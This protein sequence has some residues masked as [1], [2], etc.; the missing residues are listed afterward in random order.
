MNKILLAPFL[1]LFFLAG[2]NYA[3][4]AQNAKTDSLHNIISQQRKDVN[5]YLALAAL[6]DHFKGTK[7]DS[8]VFYAEKVAAA[9]AGKDF[10]VARITANGAVGYA[11][12]IKGELPLASA[13]FEDNARLN[14]L[15]NDSAGVANAVNNQGN[16]LLEMGN[17]SGALEKYRA[18]LAVMEAIHNKK[19]VA[20]ANNNIGYIYK[21]LGDYDRAIASMLA[22]LRTMEQLGD[23][24]SIANNCTMLSAVYTRKKDF[25]RAAEYARRAKELYLQTGQNQ[26]VGISLSLLANVYQE[27]GKYDEAMNTHREALAIYEKAG[28][29]RQI[30]NTNGY[31]GEILS[32]QER[33]AEAIPYIDSSI[34]ILQKVSRRSLGSAWLS[35]ARNYINTKNLKGSRIH[36]DSAAGIIAE[37]KNKEN[38]RDLYEL[39]ALYNAA[40]GNNKKALEYAFL[41]ASQKDSLLTEANVKSINDLSVRYETEKK[42]LQINLLA[43]ESTVQQLQLRN[44]KLLLDEQLYRLAQNKL[45]LAQSDL[46]LAQNALTLKNLDEVILNQRLEST[47]KSARVDSLQRISE[48]QNLEIRNR[49]LEVSRRNSIIAALAGLFLLGALL[50]YSL[51]RRSRLKAEA[52]LQEVALRQQQESA[53]AVLA[54]EEAERSRIARDLHDGLGQM[55]SATKLNLSAYARAT[56]FKSEEER[57]AFNNIIGLVDSSYNEVRSVSH[58]MMPNALLKNSLA[59]AVRDFVN[60]MDQRRLKVHLLAEGLDERLDINIETVIY[61]VIQE[62]VNNVIKHSGADTLHISL[63]KDSDALT[64]TVEDNG[65]GFEVRGKTGDGIGLKN[66]R[67]RME[68]LKGSVDFSSTPGEGTLVALYVPL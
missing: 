9:P 20:M 58:N 63:I 68:Y 27:E 14:A 50:A 51:Y 13:A 5:F 53:A 67:T 16:I 60:Q 8:A 39:E 38:L 54:A 32:R 66:I 15:R 42:E 2:N 57:L 49:K 3:A 44:Q 33:Y 19:G 62:C 64:A 18:A 47:V 4:Q 59:A 41:Y 45:V 24:N 26:G 7:P 46:K 48:V 10:Y 17:Y 1:V 25:S 43:K 52:R 21:D 30:G 37:T 23:K 6:A 61:R 40:A 55:M 31:I 28:D 56:G 22:G 36:L 11:R 35:Q 34:S 29:R 65:K 12:Y